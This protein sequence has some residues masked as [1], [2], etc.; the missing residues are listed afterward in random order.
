ML[1]R[2]RGC[3]MSKGVRYRPQQCNIGYPDLMNHIMAVRMRDWEIMYLGREEAE[4]RFAERRLIR[5]LNR[6][7]QRFASQR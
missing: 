2:N 6:K 1:L 5:K 3:R 4:R 7:R